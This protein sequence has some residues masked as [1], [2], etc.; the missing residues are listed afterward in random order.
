MAN[1]NFHRGYEWWLMK[2]ARLRNPAII[3]DCLEWGAPAWVGIL[4]NVISGTAPNAGDGSVTV[5]VTDGGAL[6]QRVDYG[7]DVFGNLT[8]QTDARNCVTAITYD[9][10]NRPR[11]KT[12]SG[13]GACDSTPDVTYAYDSTN[14]GNEGIGTGHAHAYVTIAVGNALI[15]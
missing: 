6:L 12:Y 10:L 7:Y 15:V 5:R 14:N 2:E 8:S 1:P 4:G 11:T 9:D 13:P 3:L